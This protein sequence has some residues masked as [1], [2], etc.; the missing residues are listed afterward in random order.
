MHNKKHLKPRKNNAHKAFI[1]TTCANITL[2]IK[3]QD[4]KKCDYD[5]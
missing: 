1:K 5:T 4:I 3:L 2:I